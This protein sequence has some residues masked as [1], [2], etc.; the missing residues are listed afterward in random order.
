MPLPALINDNNYKIKF[1]H[2][3]T[4]QTEQFAGWVTQFTDNY[5]A[6]WNPESVYGRMDNLATFQR[7]TRSLNL[8]FDVVAANALEA[9]RNLQKISRLIRFLYPVYTGATRSAQNTLAGGPLLGLKWTNMITSMVDGSYLY[10]Y[11]GGLNYAP[12]VVDGA[13]LSVPDNDPG[14]VF[15]EAYKISKGILDSTPDDSPI[16]EGI[17]QQ[18]EMMRVIATSLPA[19][20]VGVGGVYLPKSVSLTFDFTVIHTHLTGFNDKKFAGD[21]SGVNFPYRSNLLLGRATMP[22]G[23]PPDNPAAAGADTADVTGGDSGSGVSVEE[24]AAVDDDTAEGE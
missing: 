4:G 2:V 13:F 18:A 10:G 15:D 24:P 20:K 16:R 21:A 19:G 17:A 3:P 12:N 23:T 6:N 11:L 8:A 5:T 1:L 7:T 9:Q 14:A 22:P